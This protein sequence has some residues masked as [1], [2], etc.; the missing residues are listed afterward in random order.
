MH[1]GDQIKT[2]KKTVRPEL[3]EG[4]TRKS[5]KPLA[6]VFTFFRSFC[7]FRGQKKSGRD[8]YLYDFSDVN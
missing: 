4:W 6:L 3:I 2:R 8:Y 7:V 5:R 1:M